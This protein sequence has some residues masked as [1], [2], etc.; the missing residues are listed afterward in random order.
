M[1]KNVLK[2]SNVAYNEVN[3]SEDAEAT[4]LVQR[5]GYKS[6]PVVVAGDNHWSGFKLDKLKD[7]I[8]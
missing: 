2:K 8:K 6:A 3:L 1:T 7:L 5:L 4:L